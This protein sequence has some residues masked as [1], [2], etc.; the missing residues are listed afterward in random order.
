MSL[1]ANQEKET[2]L[3]NKIQWSTKDD[4]GKGALTQSISKPTS[5]DSS[6]T[7]NPMEIKTFF[8]YV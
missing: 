8:V 3:A 5:S 6:V 7:L 2:M 4:E 1:S